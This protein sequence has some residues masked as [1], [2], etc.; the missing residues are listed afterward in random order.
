MLNTLVR[1]P[2]RRGREWWHFRPLAQIAIALLANALVFCVLA[3]VL[4]LKALL[5]PCLVSMI[6]A[7]VLYSLSGTSEFRLNPGDRHNPLRDNIEELVAANRKLK[8]R[9][10]YAAERERE[11]L[12]QQIKKLRGRPQAIQKQE[13]EARDTTYVEA[14]QA[15]R[16][17]ASRA[18]DTRLRQEREIDRARL[19]ALGPGS[20]K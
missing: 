4:V 1:Q 19:K 8:K 7:A 14:T 6:G 20:E 15:D 12:S 10:G 9:K 18:A 11:S 5:A 13:R 16:N 2:Y 3:T 17:L